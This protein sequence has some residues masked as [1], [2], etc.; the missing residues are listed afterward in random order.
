MYIPEPYAVGDREVLY[1]VIK[2]NNFGLLINQAEGAL[3]ATHLPFLIEG[4]VLVAHMARANA[5]TC[6]SSEIP[7][8]IRASTR[9]R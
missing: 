2:E 7:G 5:S 9:S 4:D 6:S 3:F 1:G 8:S